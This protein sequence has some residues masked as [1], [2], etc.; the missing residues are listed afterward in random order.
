M[1][2]LRVL[3]LLVVDGGHGCHRGVVLVLAAAGHRA[4][5]HS[6]TAILTRG[7]ILAAASSRS[8]HL[9]SRP[10]EEAIGQSRAELAVSRAR[11]LPL[12]HPDLKK[13]KQIK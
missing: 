11:C 8:S 9:I 2:Q 1:R 13:K 4:V 7:V 6:K 3:L 10:E 12:T 5:R